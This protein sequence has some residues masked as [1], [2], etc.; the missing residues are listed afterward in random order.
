M[1]EQITK[2]HIKKCDGCD[3]HCELG[4]TKV[5]GHRYLPKIGNCEIRSYIDENDQVIKT[6]DIYTFSDIEAIKKARQIAKLCD[7]H[8]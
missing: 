7:H 8:R 2:K 5:R 1:F 3:K 6:F 4:A